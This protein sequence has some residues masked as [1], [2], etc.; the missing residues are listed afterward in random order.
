MSRKGER[1]RVQTGEAA[2]QVASYG[3]STRTFRLESPSFQGR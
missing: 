1:R 2:Q 3:E